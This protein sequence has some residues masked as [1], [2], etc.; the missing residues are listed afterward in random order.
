VTDR[1]Q[2][3]CSSASAQR[4]QA[5]EEAEFQQ[6]A[7]ASLHTQCGLEAREDFKNVWPILSA[8][9][10]VAYAFFGPLA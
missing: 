2:I 3:R 1:R 5:A 6:H 10:F 8:S 7:G 9:D 4:R